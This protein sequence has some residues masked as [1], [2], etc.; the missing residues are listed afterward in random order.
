MKN[1]TSIFETFWNDIDVDTKIHRTCF[2]N[3]P[4]VRRRWKFTTRTFRLSTFRGCR[5]AR[6]RML[7][8]ILRI[9]SRCLLDRLGP[10]TRSLPSHHHSFTRRLALDFQHHPGNVFSIRSPCGL[11]YRPARPML[12][13]IRFAMAGIHNTA[14]GIYYGC[15]KSSEACL[16]VCLSVRTLQRACFVRLRSRHLTSLC[17][18]AVRGRITFLHHCCASKFPLAF[19]LLLFRL[20]NRSVIGFSSLDNN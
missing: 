8:A 7:A 13:P 9:T 14:N 15:Q 2:S 11:T 19:C 20:D 18:L 10:S 1:T 3:R 4:K 5:L 16:S 17:A 12:S 6:E